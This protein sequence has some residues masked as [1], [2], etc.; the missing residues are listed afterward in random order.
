MLD[1][2]VE[3]NKSGT[4]YILLA[5][6]SLVIIIFSIIFTYINKKRFKNED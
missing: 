6:L 1:K 3:F 2:I 5:I 4:E